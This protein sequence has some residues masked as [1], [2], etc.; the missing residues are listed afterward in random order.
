MKNIP[1]NMYIPHVKNGPKVAISLDFFVTHF[2]VLSLIS[3]LLIN[4]YL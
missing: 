2:C 1:P 4:K 3:V